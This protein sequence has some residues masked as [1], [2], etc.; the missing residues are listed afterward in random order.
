MPPPSWPTP[1]PIVKPEIDTESPAATE[2]T[3]NPSVDL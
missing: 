1:L 3:E 2:K